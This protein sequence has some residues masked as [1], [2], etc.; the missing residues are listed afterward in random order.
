MSTKHLG[1]QAS[2]PIALTF[3][4]PV[5]L[6]LVNM[7]VPERHRDGWFIKMVFEHDAA[8]ASLSLPVLAFML[9]F[10]SQMSKRTP[11]TVLIVTA[12][13]ALLLAA[14]VGMIAIFDDETNFLGSE[15]QQYWLIGFVLLQTIPPLL[16]LLWLNHHKMSAVQG[17][18][19]EESS[20]ESG[21]AHK[22]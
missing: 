21:C 12:P 3:W 9:I 4:L 5:L 15:S 22:S 19:S 1:R 6:V 7:A 11:E 16:A 17:P 10:L 8:L 2:I 18:T 14:V 20:G 13:V